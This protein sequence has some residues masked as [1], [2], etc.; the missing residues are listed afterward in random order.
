M[1]IAGFTRTVYTSGGALARGRVEYITRTGKYASPA[2]ARIQHQGLD[3][4]TGTVRED[5]VYW[6]ARNLPQWA[7][8][9]PVRFFSTAEQHERVGGVA[10]TEWRFALPREFTHRENMDLARDVL[11]MSFG[12]EH[13]YCFAFHDPPAADGGTQPHVHVLWSART[14]DG[15]D[16]TEEQFFKRW[17]ATQPERGGARKDPE[18]NHMGA[19]KAARVQY[20]DIVNA[21]LEQ[22]GYQMRL[23]P[24]SLKDRG[25]DRTPEPKLLP[26]DSNRLKHHYEVTERMQTVFDHRHAREQSAPAELADAQQYW[27][28]RKR[29]L[30][31][32]TSMPMNQKLQHIREAREQAVSTVP[33]R[34]PVQD[35]ARE[36]RTLK[37]SIARLELYSTELRLEQAAESWFREDFQRLETGKHSAE[38]LLARGP[39]YGL[40][41]DLQAEHFV[42]SHA[43][44]PQAGAA[45]RIRLFERDEHERDQGIGF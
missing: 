5:L 11:Q 4:D 1:A 22:G 34:L 19:V 2:E 14:L 21:H 38:R 27:Q 40:P 37:Q 26:S 7:K 32:T 28:E 30:G 42:A 13:P 17:N 8:D 31:I 10:Y 3:A 33:E 45:L 24:D 35:L 29:E 23:H 16:R 43:Q 41:P 36:A 18:M 44:E 39:D 9:D 25:I 20:V 12:E 15:L 6:R